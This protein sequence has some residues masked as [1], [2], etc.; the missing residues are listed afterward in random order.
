MAPSGYAPTALVLHAQYP[1][2]YSGGQPSAVSQTPGSI[3]LDIS[4]PRNIGGT[5]G[6]E[7]FAYF[8]R[9]GSAIGGVGYD[10]TENAYAM[11]LGQSV[12][13]GVN[14]A[15]AGDGTNLLLNTVSGAGA[16]DFMGA[17]SVR[18]YL[19]GTDL[20]VTSGINLDVGGGPLGGGAGV[21]T[22]HDGT[23]PTSA[24]T[25]GGVLCSSGGDL[26]WCY[27]STDA[28]APHCSKL[29]GP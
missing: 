8:S 22:L 24:I 10:P 29:A 17:G 2:T 4:S 23:C 6:Q 26:Q 16:I 21:I 20:I 1:A 19:S 28:G 15:I 27:G 9:N 18:E 14:F 7:A 5:P 12:C 11:W 25:G 13:G 3:F